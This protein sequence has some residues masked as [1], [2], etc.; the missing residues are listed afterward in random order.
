[1][2]DEPKP[3]SE[4][5]RKRAAG[6]ARRK[7]LIE[8]REVI[9]NALTSGYSVPWIAHTAKMSVAAVRRAIAQALADRRLD[10]PEDYARLQVA[11][12]NKALVCADVLLE[13]GEVKA[14][15]HFVRVVAELDRYHGLVRP[16][17]LGKPARRP[18]GPRL[19]PPP[20]ALTDA[21]ETSTLFAAPRREGALDPRQMD[22]PSRAPGALVEQNA[23]S[24]ESR[25]KEV[26]SVWFQ[27]RS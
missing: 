21:S 8:Q 16:M 4:W 9:F 7:R 27:E 20:L 1:M 24:R 10:S 25:A 17:R 13:E 3:P 12:L 26:V 22:A 2:S 11:R 14:I 23:Q 6:K 19:P 18:R 15:P 5:A